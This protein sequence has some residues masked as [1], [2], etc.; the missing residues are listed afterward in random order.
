MP[1]YNN[2]NNNLIKK[3]MQKRYPY[4]EACGNEMVKYANIIIR[5][6]N[7]LALITLIMGSRISLFIKELK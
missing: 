6:V 7:C 1:L 3:L 5:Y 4:A 2:Q